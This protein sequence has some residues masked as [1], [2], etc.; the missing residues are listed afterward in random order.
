MS[1][2]TTTAILIRSGTKYNNGQFQCMQRCPC[3]P[4]CSPS[5]SPQTVSFIFCLLRAKPTTKTT[6]IKL[7]P[8]CCR[9]RLPNFIL[10]K[11][12]QAFTREKKRA[13]MES[14]DAFAAQAEV[15]ADRMRKQASASLQKVMLSKNYH[16]EPTYLKLH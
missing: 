3:R 16:T 14:E 10:C 6:L 2:N 13:L 12:N 15:M 1:S 5:L 9:N 4:P 11:P 8:P 7:K